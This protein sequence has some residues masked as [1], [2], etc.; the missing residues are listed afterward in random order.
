MRKTFV[1]LKKNDL[2]ITVYGSLKALHLANNEYLNISLSTLQHFDFSQDYETENYKI[3][4]DFAKTA[5]EI[6]KDLGSL[7]INI[8]V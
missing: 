7:L 8:L 2:Q 1:L 3:H 6:R 5:N 4:A